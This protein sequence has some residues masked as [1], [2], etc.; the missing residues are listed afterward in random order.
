MKIKERLEDLLPAAGGSGI[1]MLCG[2]G[3]AEAL[4]HPQAYETVQQIQQGTANMMPHTAGEAAISLA[5]TGAF[6]LVTGLLVTYNRIMERLNS[7]EKL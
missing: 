7:Y 5:V 2:W 1:G 4:K 3:A 6:F